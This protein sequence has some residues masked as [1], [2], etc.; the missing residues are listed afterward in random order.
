MTSELVSFRESRINLE[1]SGCWRY[2][3]V[4]SSRL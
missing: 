4:A 2:S 3:A 1:V